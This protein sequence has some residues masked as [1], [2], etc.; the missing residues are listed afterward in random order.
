[1]VTFAETLPAGNT[2]QIWQLA[3]TT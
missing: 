1:M 2:N 3:T